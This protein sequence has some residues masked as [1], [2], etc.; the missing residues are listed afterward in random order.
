MK[1][2]P[3]SRAAVVGSG[4]NGL[5]AAVTLAR[6]GIEVTVFE[7]QTKIGG[8]ARTVPWVQ[9]D[10]LHDTCSSI[11]PLA[12]ATGFFREFELER[13]VGFV[14]PEASYACTGVERNQR[15]TA[16]A[17]RDI[18]RT[19]EELGRDGRAY[20]AF[21]SP[22]LR[23]MDEIIDI[24][25][26]G[27][28]LR[29]PRSAVAAGVFGSAVVEQTT[30]LRHLRFRDEAAPTLIAGVVGH[31][32]GR[33]PSLA[34]SGVGV[35]L[36]ALA[37][38]TGW[39]VPVGGSQA[40]TDA[41]AADLLR[42]GGTIETSTRITNIRELDRYDVKMFDTSAPAL[43]RIAADT[44]PARYRKRLA[45][46]RHGDAAAKVDFVLDGPIPWA[47]ERVSSTPTVH[48]GAT[49]SELYTSEREVSLGTVPERPYVV[50]TQPTSN[51]PGRT[52]EGL[53]AVSSY[54]H[55]PRGCDVDMSAAV[56]AQIERAAPG[57]RDRIVACRS[58]RAS[59][60]SAFNENYVDGDINIGAIT[61][62]T[63]LA[64]PVLSRTP[65]RTP[66]PGVYLCSSATPPGPGVHGL[67]GWYAAQA[68]LRHEYGL[69][70]PDLSTSAAAAAA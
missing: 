51:D 48:L 5:A 7:A 33:L 55:V 42:H 45:M 47:D 19:A 41:L 65:W 22:L 70:S 67:S 61:I 38:A 28:L 64:R 52:P 62:P 34:S 59:E 56:I 36:G 69:T 24:T 12:L 26:G 8:G 53:H 37:H 21:Y 43:A 32:I 2:F 30:F 10:V 11:H 58:T 54:C 66:A 18:A 6:A 1:R 63:M 14:V 49:S 40:I 57:F 39:P 29:L 50:L 20:S 68:A 9:D 23:R 27:A 25:H 3:H 31:N 44:L 17:Y 16:V 35:T 4:P 15:T 13:R 46:T 60:F